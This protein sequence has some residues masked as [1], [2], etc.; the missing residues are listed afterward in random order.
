MST[1]ATLLSS[2]SLLLVVAMSFGLTTVFRRPA[3]QRTN[4]EAEL[5]RG[6]ENVSRLLVAVLVLSLVA[7]LAAV[8]W[9]FVP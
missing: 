8:I 9:R 4:G 6:A 1:A 2:L 5:N 7:A 3:T